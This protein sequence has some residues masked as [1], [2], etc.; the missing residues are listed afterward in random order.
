MYGRDQFSGRLIKCG[1]REW[2]VSWLATDDD[3]KRLPVGFELVRSKLRGKL[4]TV[5]DPKIN[6][7]CEISRIA[8]S[9][10]SHL[11]LRGSVS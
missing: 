10:I 2:T 7:K 5:V 8:A 4:L 3:R 9:F 1:E 6:A 11:F